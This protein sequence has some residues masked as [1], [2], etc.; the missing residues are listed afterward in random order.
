[1]DTPQKTTDEQKIQQLVGMLAKKGQKLPSDAELK[2]RILRRL[3]AEDEA[4]RK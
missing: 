4:T 3:K 2:R 1:M